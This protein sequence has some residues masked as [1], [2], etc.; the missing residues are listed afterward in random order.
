[1]IQLLERFGKLINLHMVTPYRGVKIPSSNAIYQH[2]ARTESGN[3]PSLGCA[4][5]CD[6][7]RDSSTLS[8]R[9]QR[10]EVLKPF[11][12]DCLRNKQISQ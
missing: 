8:A 6:E 1:M 12:K 9:G 11:L 4:V 10:E 7:N 3:I 5:Q 2:P